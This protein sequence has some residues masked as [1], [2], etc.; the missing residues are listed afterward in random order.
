MPPSASP[1]PGRLKSDMIRA[2][3]PAPHRRQPRPRVNR[4]KLYK[5]KLFKVLFW[6][7]QWCLIVYGVVVIVWVLLQW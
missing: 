1:D 2:G 3:N 7:P 6:L 4:M 5:T